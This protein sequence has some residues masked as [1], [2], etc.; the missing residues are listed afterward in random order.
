VALA[1]VIFCLSVSA[2][3]IYNKLVFADRVCADAWK[4]PY[5]VAT[6]SLQLAVVALVLGRIRLAQ[7]CSRPL[8]LPAP[9]F[10]ARLFAR[11]LVDRYKLKH[12]APVGILFGLK[13]G[14]TNW[15]LQLV[16]TGTHL[17]L[18][19]TDVPLG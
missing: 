10:V 8:E 12:C 13:Y 18:Q 15:G 2:V 1:T 4:F 6:A 11:G 5:P 3:P 9:R 7:R 19:S 16:P 17:L 14:V